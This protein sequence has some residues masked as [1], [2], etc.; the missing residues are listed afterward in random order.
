MRDGDGRGGGAAAAVDVACQGI[1]GLV[2][3]GVV[4]GVSGAGGAWPGHALG[5][6]ASEGRLCGGG[7]GGA[8][9]AF[10]RDEGVGW[11]SVLRDG[12]WW[13]RWDGPWRVVA[14]DRWSGTRTG[15]SA[16]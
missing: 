11:G 12:G 15:I 7:G 13:L 1:G 16:Q 4:V 9:Q 10:E 2:V 6:G 5:V 8:S 3:L 14:G